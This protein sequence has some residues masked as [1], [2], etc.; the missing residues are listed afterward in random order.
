MHTVGGTKP[1]W[2]D[3]GVVPDWVARKDPPQ[4]LLDSFA[5]FA[6]TRRFS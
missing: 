6:R 4:W 2:L 5:M 1:D 3:S